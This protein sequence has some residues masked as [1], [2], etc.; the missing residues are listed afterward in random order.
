VVLLDSHDLSF[1]PWAEIRRKP[2]PRF[3]DMSVLLLLSNVRQLALGSTRL[4]PQITLPWLIRKKH[5]Q[6]YFQQLRE[7]KLQA[8]SRTTLADVSSWLLLPHLEALMVDKLAADEHLPESFSQ[9]SYDWPFG[10][11]T[12]NVEHLVFFKA[13]AKAETLG[14]MLKTLKSLRTF[15]WEDDM[16][17][18]LPSDSSDSED[19]YVP[20]NGNKR[21]VEAVREN[22]LESPVESDSDEM[23]DDVEEELPPYIRDRV[24]E[25]VLFK[26]NKLLMHLSLNYQAS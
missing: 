13:T 23:E 18:K 19:D 21:V 20:S 1:I 16:S 11:H 25:P 22:W 26:P 2:N 5:G 14:E 24:N 9:P 10:K 15:V 3:Y 12:S 7:L 6:Q 4:G 8:M 17:Y